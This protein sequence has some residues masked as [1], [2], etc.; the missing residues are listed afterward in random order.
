MKTTKTK[1]TN[2]DDEIND[3]NDENDN[4]DENNDA[5]DADDDDDDGNDDGETDDD[6]T[7]RPAPA[8]SRS[9]WCA[10]PAQHASPSLWRCCCA[11]G[12]SASRGEGGGGAAGSPCGREL[13]RATSEALSTKVSKQA[14]A[15]ALKSKTSRSEVEALLTA[16]AESL[17]PALAAKAD[18]ETVSAALSAKASKA[19]L[20]EV[21]TARV[22]ESAAELERQLG[23]I[24]SCGA[25]VSNDE[26]VWRQLFPDRD[27]YLQART[28][29]YFHFL[30]AALS[31]HQVSVSASL[32]TQLT[33]FA[34][35]EGSIKE[36]GFYVNVLRTAAPYVFKPSNIA[37]RIWASWRCSQSECANRAGT[38]AT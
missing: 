38:E 4:D 10:A 35:V 13:R 27:T 31:R 28:A 14:V 1:T 2:H 22:A 18:M 25:F 16:Q 6:T 33:A 7:T 30:A 11:L 23:L 29:E 15:A 20:R 37:G 5:T 8:C 9:R 32:W 17:A 21:V 34:L 3:E 24:L 12:W 36:L 19:E 26:S